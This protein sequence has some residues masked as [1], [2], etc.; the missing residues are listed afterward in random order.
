M[1]FHQTCA[2]ILL[3]SGFE[4]LMAKFCQCLTELSTC[5]TSLFKFQDNNL[6]KSQL[7]YTKFDMCIVNVEI[8]DG[9]AHWQISSS[10]DRNICLRHDNSGVLSFHVFISIVYTCLFGYNTVV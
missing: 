4:L 5:N 2:L 3:T 10:F 7:I 9:I 6:S 1:D 8:W